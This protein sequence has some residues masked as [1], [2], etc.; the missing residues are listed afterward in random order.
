METNYTDYIESGGREDLLHERALKYD[1]MASDFGG[2]IG[3][4][5]TIFRIAL[6][7][8]PA[9]KIRALK[10]SVGN[11]RF[12]DTVEELERLRML[13]GLTEADAER[14]WHRTERKWV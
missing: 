3:A 5:G 1:N 11:Y 6:I 7:L 12:A 9:P 13:H 8:G 2:G 14:T 10:I 4:P